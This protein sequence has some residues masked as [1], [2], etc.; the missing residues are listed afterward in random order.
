MIDGRTLNINK[1]EI[2]VFGSNL[3]GLHGRGA[4]LWA[5]KHYEAKTGVGK[6]L[7][8]Q[9][10]ALPTK[11]ENLKVL[12]LSEIKKYAD[13]FILFAKEHI[14]YNFILTPVGCGL[15]GYTALAI[16]P[17]F[18]KATELNNVKIPYEFQSIYDAEKAFSVSPNKLRNRPAPK[19]E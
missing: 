17:L 1:P 12:P 2:F 7:T 16:A 5:Y 13:E 10:Y 3:A 18:K 11:D 19:M 9:S 8:G 15:A 14:I 4:A 6:G